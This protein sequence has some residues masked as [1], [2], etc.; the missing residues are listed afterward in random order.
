MSSG[1]EEARGIIAYFLALQHVLRRYRQTGEHST[2]HWWWIN[3]D[4]SF[5]YH[6]FSLIDACASAVAFGL[7]DRRLHT[8][9]TTRWSGVLSSG[10]RIDN[11]KLIV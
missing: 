10:N 8:P 5:Q 7:E 1:F 4:L 3:M 2:T 9:V 6:R 11:L